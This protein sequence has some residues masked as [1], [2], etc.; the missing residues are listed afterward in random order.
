MNRRLAN[1]QCSKLCRESE[2]LVR[3]LTSLNAFEIAI[4]KIRI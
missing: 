1:V 3:T 4:G 2:Y